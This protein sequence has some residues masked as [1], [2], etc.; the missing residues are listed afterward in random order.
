VSQGSL[1]EAKGTK[2]FGLDP[3]RQSLNIEHNFVGKGSAIQVV[4]AR[5]MPFA[6]AFKACPQ[7][8]ILIFVHFFG[9]KGHNRQKRSG[10]PVFM[11]NFI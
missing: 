8:K 1:C 11:L 10:K 3:Y 7:A 6:N 2:F 5:T 9:K 4:S